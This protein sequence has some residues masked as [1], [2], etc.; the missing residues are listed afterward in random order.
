MTQLCRTFPVQE[1][2]E[3]SYWDG[4]DADAPVIPVRLTVFRDGFPFGVA[5]FD[6]TPR[7]EDGVRVLDDGDK[8]FIRS[9]LA[10]GVQMT[11]KNSGLQADAVVCAVGAH[12]HTAPPRAA[13]DGWVV[14]QRPLSLTVSAAGVVSALESGGPLSIRNL[15]TGLQ[16]DDMEVPSGEAFSLDLPAGSYYAGIYP[17]DLR[18]AFTGTNFEI[19]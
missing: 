2:K 11:L 12:N 1:I 5:A 13:V 16:Y 7:V 9:S 4:W 17:R 8:E 6:Y 18:Y 3:Q 14:E 15:D 19:A 10:S